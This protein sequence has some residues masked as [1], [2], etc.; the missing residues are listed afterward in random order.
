MKLKLI[1][2][3]LANSTAGLIDLN[4]VQKQ[5]VLFANSLVDEMNDFYVHVLEGTPKENQSL[6][7]IIKFP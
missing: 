4:L 3:I 1:D 6:E 7:N 2:M 5:K